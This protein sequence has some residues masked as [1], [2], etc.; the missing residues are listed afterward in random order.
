MNPYTD[1]KTA[2]NVFR[3][4]MSVIGPRPYIPY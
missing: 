1:L 2:L 4:E 3:G